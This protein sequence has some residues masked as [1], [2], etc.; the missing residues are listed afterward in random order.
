M[1]ISETTTAS[2]EGHHAKNRQSRSELLNGLG[3]SLIGTGIAAI[4]LQT[5]GVSVINT[6][7]FVGRGIALYAAFQLVPF[8]RKHVDAKLNRTL[9]AMAAVWVLSVLAQGLSLATA[10]ARPLIISIALVD[11]VLRSISLAQARS[12]TTQLRRSVANTLVIGSIARIGT[13]AMMVTLATSGA[14]RLSMSAGMIVVAELGASLLAATFVELSLPKHFAAKA[15]QSSTMV[16]S[17]VMTDEVTQAASVTADDSIDVVLDLRHTDAPQKPALT[18][19]VVD[20][21]EHAEA[22][23]H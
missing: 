20:L 21:R 4:A 19:T 6:L 8:F 2:A 16:T 1:T 3:I 10:F 15:Q 12:V 18:D 7:S 5:Q 14:T 13:G 17:E 22:A 9:K 23:T 11:F